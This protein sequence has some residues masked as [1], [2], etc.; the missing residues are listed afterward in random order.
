MPACRRTARMLRGLQNHNTPGNRERRSRREARSYRLRS[1]DVAVYD[2]GGEGGEWCVRGFGRAVRRQGRLL[3][4]DRDSGEVLLAQDGR[5]RDGSPAAGG[6]SR[7]GELLVVWHDRVSKE[8]H[9]LM[10]GE[11]AC[12]EAVW[13]FLEQ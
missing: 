2:R 5:C 11:R 9:G 13:R 7:L 6:V 3:V 10:F 4:R 8:E 12:C 1:D